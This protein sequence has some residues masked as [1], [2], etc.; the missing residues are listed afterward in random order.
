MSTSDEFARL[1]KLFASRRGRWTFCYTAREVGEQHV[2][3]DAWPLYHDVP[4]GTFTGPETDYAQMAC[5]A[6]NVLP[7]M[8]DDAERLQ[9]RIKQ[10]EDG[11]LMIRAHAE[12]TEARPGRET[13]QRKIDEISQVAHRVLTD[14][15]ETGQE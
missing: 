1:R 4:I 3:Q 13:L 11:L 5:E 7:E 6:V 15:P 8:L 2:F 14:R 12:S 10:L 9:A